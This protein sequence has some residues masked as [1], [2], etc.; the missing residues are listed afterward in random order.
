MKNLKSIKT[1]IL[2]LTSASQFYYDYSPFLN[3][4]EDHK[5]LA[6]QIKQQINFALKKSEQNS[7]HV[8]FTIENIHKTAIF[9]F[10]SVV[11]KDSPNIIKEKYKHAPNF[12]INKYFLIKESDSTKIYLQSSQYFENDIENLDLDFSSFKLEW[13]RRESIPYSPFD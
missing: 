12:I 10:H 1:K 13:Q 3:D 6:Q 2:E 8:L 11:T 4:G 9:L 7:I 5:N